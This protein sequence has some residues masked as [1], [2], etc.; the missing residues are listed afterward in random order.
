[1]DRLAQVEF[2]RG[3]ITYILALGTIAIAVLLVVGA[4][5]GDE[6][7][8]DNFS[9][10]KEILSILVGI[11]G[12]ILGFYY[13]SEKSE[14]AGLA[15]SPISIVKSVDGAEATLV[16]TVTGGRAPYHYAIKF[17]DANLTGTIKEKI[18]TSKETENKPVG[19]TISVSD[20]DKN[21]LSHEA[22]DQE[23]L[24]GKSLEP[25]AKAA[26]SQSPN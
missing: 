2:A 19:F 22:T 17:D 9:R 12:T 21:Q 23:K 25:A 4:M 18:D 24:T 15:L 20:A 6:A 1:M 10:G 5:L 11:F 14:K 7:N 13:G 8:K 26:R 3:L 16:A